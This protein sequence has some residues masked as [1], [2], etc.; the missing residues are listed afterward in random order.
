[1]CSNFLH[2]HFN[3]NKTKQKI[4]YNYET[5]NFPHPC[6]LGLFPCFGECS[7]YC[8]LRILFSIHPVYIE[9]LFFFLQIVLVRFKFDCTA[10]N[11][12]R[13]IIVLSESRATVLFFFLFFEIFEFLVR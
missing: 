10:T 7:K 8:T 11:N 9:I 4:V 1:M 3:Q 6:L 5:I 12:C 2:K 13:E